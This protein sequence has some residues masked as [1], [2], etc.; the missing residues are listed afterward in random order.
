MPPR[1]I[2]ATIVAG[3]LATAGWFASEKWLPWLRT[4]DEPAF[5]VEL[6]DEVATQQASW[7]LY[8]KEKR[9]GAA[10]TRMAP[11]KDG[12]F[13]LTTRLRDLEVSY[14]VADVKMPVFSTTRTVTRSGDLLR[15]DARAVM[16]VRARLLGVDLKT[17][18]TVRGEVIGNEFRG[19]CEYDYGSGK[20][21]HPLDPI[22]LVSKNA[23]SPLQPFQK[24][25]P[26]RPGQTWRVS[27]LDPV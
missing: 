7:L 23:F 8:R 16:I 2:V 24:F 26:L 3:W 13:D 21:K 5:V 10:E 1:L 19:E 27:N 6:A 22:R 15:L 9:I 11:R 18:A 4:S 20:T 25:P 17:D 12:T 14:G